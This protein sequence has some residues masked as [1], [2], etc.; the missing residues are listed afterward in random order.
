MP[1]K[2]NTTYDKPDLEKK[3]RYFKIYE[4]CTVHVANKVASMAA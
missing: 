4:R 2:L 1:Y 3:T